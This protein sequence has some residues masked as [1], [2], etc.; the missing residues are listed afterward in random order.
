MGMV[1]GGDKSAT[2]SKYNGFT[3]INGGWRDHPLD[4]VGG[5]GEVRAEGDFLQIRTSKHVFPTPCI[6]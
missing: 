5:R 6:S 3:G 1:K 4:R 2:P